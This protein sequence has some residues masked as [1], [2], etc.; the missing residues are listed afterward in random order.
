[1]RRYL[2]VAACL[3]A[4]LGAAG[5]MAA[6]ASAGGSRPA[7][8]ECAKVKKNAAKKYEG[9]YKNGCVKENSKGEGEYEVKEGIGKGKLMKAKGRREP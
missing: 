2:V 3:S 4:T 7:L 1:M 6:G 5:V 8:F 9:R